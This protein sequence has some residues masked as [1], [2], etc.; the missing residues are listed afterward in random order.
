MTEAERYRKRRAYFQAY[1]RLNK[2]RR[3]ENAKRWREG[4]RQ[5]YNAMQREFNR[6]YRQQAGATPR[7]VKPKA[8][9]KPI[10]TGQGLRE[11]FLSY[12]Q[13]KQTA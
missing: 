13:N 3:A 7:P 6:R 5:A 8:Q 1:A 9:P 11:R 2:E 12:R 10:I 4:N